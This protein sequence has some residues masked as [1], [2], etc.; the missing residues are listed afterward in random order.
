MFL[1]LVGLGIS[2]LPIGH[3]CKNASLAHDCGD[4][5]ICNSSGKCDA[6]VIN[7]SQCMKHF[8]CRESKRLGSNICNYEPLTH[9]WD[10]RLIIGIICVFIAGIFVSGA[11]IGGG[12]LFVPIMML[13]VNFPTSYAIPTS[14]AIIFGGSLAVTLFNLNKR[15][16]Y[17]ERPL[18]NYNVAAMI[19]PI[20]W[21]GTVIGVIFNS[22]IPEWLLYSV[23]FVLLTYTAWNT[24]K[25]GLKDQRNAK[26]G[27]SPNNELLVK[28]TY[29]GPTYSIGLLWL[30]L[31]I[32]VVFL[33][34]SFLRGGD[35]ADS[36][37][38]IKFCSPIYWALTFGPFPIYLGITAW[39]V[40]I[41]KRYPV[42]GHKNELTKKDI[43]LLMMS[44]FVAGMAAGF[45]GIGGGMIKGPMMLALEI[46]AE[47]MAAT[48]SF[49]ILMTSSA[50]S[51]QYI[52]E[53][54][55]P[56][57]EF[58]VFTS[59]GFVSFL[60]GVIF[61]RWLV[62]KLGNRSIFLYFLAAIIMISA[63]LMSVVGIEIIILEVKEHA[64]MGFRPFC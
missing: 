57:L 46:E 17:Y 51:I 55:M 49:M 56:W 28:G 19:E 2:A 31:I 45:L 20:S 43:F 5:L 44:G 21:L 25:K 61:L 63:I 36:I 16:P 30:L 54:L 14:K 12:G 39:M 41:A 47:E 40:H 34:I 48:S 62:K 24:F 35:G 18:I 4:Y 38:G 10:T 33:A 15:H 11:G 29:D 59:M 53:G 26:L 9:K 6:C 7:K 60:I 50:T 13:L 1:L 42:L 58:G 37:I 23:Q 52:A 22:I 27:I 64:S 3:T 8:Y 32:Y